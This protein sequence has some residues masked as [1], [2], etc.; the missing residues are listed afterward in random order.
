MQMVPL[1][2]DVPG[3]DNDLNEKFD[4]IVQRALADE[5]AEIFA[6]GAAWGPEPA[7]PDNYFGFSPGRGIHEVHMNQ[8]NSGDFRYADGVWQDGGLLFYFPEQRQWV[9]VFTAFQSQAWHTDDSTGH[10]L[11]GPAPQ[12]GE[13]SRPNHPTEDLLPTEGV[14]DGLVRIVGALVNDSRSPER[15]VVTLLNRSNRDISLSGWSLADKNKAKMPLGGSLA[16]GA[17]VQVTVQTPVALSNKGGIITVL[18]S[19]GRK[20]HGVSYTKEE[21][22]HVGWTIPF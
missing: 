15:E 9:A 11:A 7:R 16:A 10:A 5:T 13:D 3:P 22:S 17:T 4:A 21:A 19:E 14:P 8:G 1:P 18:D 12:P 6:Y 20:I 2:H